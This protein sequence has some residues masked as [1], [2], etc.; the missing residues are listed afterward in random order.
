MGEPTDTGPAAGPDP[1][2]GPPSVPGH[3]AAPRSLGSWWRAV[4]GPPT[5]QL[6]LPRLTA[7][8]SVDVAVVGAGFCGLWVAHHLQRRRPGCRVAVLEAGVPGEGGSG[9]M[10]GCTSPLPAFIAGGGAD[11]S[12]LD[13][14][15]ATADRVERWLAEAGVEAAWRRGPSVALAVQRSELRRLGLALRM[16][17]RLGMRDDVLAWR[18]PEPGQRRPALDGVLGML[19]MADGIA[20]QPRRLVEGLATWVRGQGAQLYGQSAVRSVSRHEVTTDHGRIKA[21]AVVV[22]AGTALE[23]LLPAAA[24]QVALAQWHHLVTEPI[25]EVTWARLGWP[26]QH[27]MF[28]HGPQGQIQAQHGPGDRLVWGWRPSPVPRRWP[29][30]PPTLAERSAQ[31][32]D[33]VLSAL[34]AS[35]TVRVARTWSNWSVAEVAPP[36]WGKVEPAGVFWLVSEQDDPLT[37]FRRAESLATVIPS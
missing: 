27:T 16:A 2:A 30:H 10:T 6:P 19:W 26:A 17:R 20:L 22:A 18:D 14:F 7:D 4:E 11:R 23:A 37:A 12:P 9:A 36:G 1:A 13:E 31:L 24:T 15:V 3:L 29:R 32:A 5:E 21:G 33:G 28:L 35:V 25:D 34:P 8:R